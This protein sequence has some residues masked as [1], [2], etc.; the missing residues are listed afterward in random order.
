MLPFN[1]VVYALE[2]FASTRQIM[3]I[4]TKILSAFVTGAIHSNPAEYL[5]TISRFCEIQSSPA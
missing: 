5:S 3:A 4:Q 1:A 2:Y